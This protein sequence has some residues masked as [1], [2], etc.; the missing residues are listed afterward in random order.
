MPPAAATIDSGL[1]AR[2]HLVAALH[3]DL[4]GPFA[5]DAATS[6]PAGATEL[7]RVNPSRWYLTGF[8]ANEVLREAEDD[9][10]E[11]ELGS[12]DD[13]EPDTNGTAEP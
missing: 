1:A 4:I 8:L 11:G 2:A 7:L 3:A 12:G 5:P 9:T 13:L 10:E 6:D